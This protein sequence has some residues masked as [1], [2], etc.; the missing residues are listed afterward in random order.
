MSSIMIRIQTQA[1]AHCP[2]CGERLI[3][4]GASLYGNVLACAPCT[5]TVPDK[6]YERILRCAES[7]ATVKFFAMPNGIFVFTPPRNYD[8]TLSPATWM[9][10]FRV[11]QLSRVVAGDRQPTGELSDLPAF[12]GSLRDLP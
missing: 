9:E 10:T 3:T 8:R 2:F 12:D 4:N 1:D 11:R 5:Q 7:L 6:E